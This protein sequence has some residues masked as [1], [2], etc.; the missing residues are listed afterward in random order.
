M[1]A[2]ADWWLTQSRPAGRK[3]ALGITIHRPA[4]PR[5]RVRPLARAGFVVALV[6]LGL[7]VFATPT[8]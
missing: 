6:I 8:G 3:V 7:A 1:R 5:P 2:A 4:P